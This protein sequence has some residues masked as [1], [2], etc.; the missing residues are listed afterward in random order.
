MASCA[1]AS[2]T[3]ALHAG[4]LPATSTTARTGMDG[5]PLGTGCLRDIETKKSH[6]EERRGKRG[7]EQGKERRKDGGRGRGRRRRSHFNSAYLGTLSGV[8]VHYAMSPIT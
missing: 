1:S 7:Y 6:Q 5:K 2:P 3:A 8:Q 4:K